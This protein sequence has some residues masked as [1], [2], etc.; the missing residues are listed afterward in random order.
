VSQYGFISVDQPGGSLKEVRSV[1]RVDGLVWNKKPESLARL[2][3][4]M[5]SMDE[6]AKRR[7]L[8]SF[9]DHGL[10]G[11]VTDLG[12]LILLFARGGTDRYEILFDRLDDAGY[13]V[14]N[15]AQLDGNE[16]FTVYG[17]G[18]QAVRQKLKGKIWVQPVDHLPARMSIDVDREVD[19]VRI[20]DVS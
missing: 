3:R 12:Q 6:K 11:F 15:Y 13:W 14:Y 10:H 19:R 1:L 18:P 7:S 16:A 9:E 5:S 4:E 8:E 2:A 17:E 20:R